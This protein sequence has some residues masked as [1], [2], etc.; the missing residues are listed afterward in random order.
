VVTHG[1][2]SGDSWHMRRLVLVLACA[3]AG[4]TAAN[5]LYSG[6]G[7]GGMDFG[8]VG[9]IGDPDLHDGGVADLAAGGD[10]PTDA[11]VRAD[12]APA[13]PA[14]LAHPGEC[15]PSER[16]CVETPTPSS[17]ACID[18]RFATDRRCPYGSF[19]RTGAGCA[20]G[21]CQPPGGANATECASEDD[22]G[23]LGGGPVRFT[24]QP[25]V[26]DAATSAIEWWCAVA[27]TTG[28]GGAGTSCSGPES[29]RNALCGSN[30]TCFYACERN[31]D[32]PARTHCAAVRLAFEGVSVG[33]RS[34]IP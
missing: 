8:G 34:C 11:A 10:A 21:Y 3:L 17:E 32:C 23:S 22:C 26:A 5:P 18:N 15:G 31:A 16:D 28:S 33:A 24:C 20:D 19:S 14:D 30:G 29:C 1:T 7:G 2:L 27:V 25:F 13:G 6:G 9:G 4:C 12:L